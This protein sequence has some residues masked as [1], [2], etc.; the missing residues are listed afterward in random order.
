[1]LVRA[2]REVSRATLQGSCRWV[3]I[4]RHASVLESERVCRLPYYGITNYQYACARTM[5]DRAWLWGGSVSLPK[6]LS[7]PL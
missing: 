7:K 1:M 6:S 4:P 3:R 2:R 5:G